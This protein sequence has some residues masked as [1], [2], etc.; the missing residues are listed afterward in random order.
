MSSISGS[1]HRRTVR[2]AAAQPTGTDLDQYLTYSLN[3]CW[4]AGLRFEWFR[5]EDG[6]RVGLNR[7]SNPN[8]PPFVGNFYSLSAGVN[9]SPTAN[10]TLRPEIRADWYDG[11]SARLPY[12]DGTDSSQLLLGLDGILRY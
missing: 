6:T 2:W 4:K 12:D 7:R 1:V 3:D 5:D 11:E 8:D 9:W 10:F